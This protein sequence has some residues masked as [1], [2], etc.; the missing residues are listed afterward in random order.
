MI[1]ADLLIK[2][3]AQLLTMAGHNETPKRGGDLADPGA[4]AGGAVAALNGVITAVG[5]TRVLEETVALL[6]HARAYDAWGKVV[7]PC[8][9]EPHTHLVFGGSRQAEFV[10]RLQGKT[11]LEIMQAGGGILNSVQATAAASFEELVETAR[12]RLDLLARH[13][14]GTVE[15]KSGYGLTVEEELRMLRVVH[16]LDRTHPLDLIPTFLGAHAFPP[17]YRGR[18]DEYVALVTGEMIPRV[19]EEKLA[20]FCDVFCDIGVFTLPQAR[21]VLEAGKEF[22]LLP[23]MH[24]DEL[25]SF[26]GAELAAELGAVSADHLLKAS[27]AGIAALAKAGVIAVLLPG[28]AFYLNED[29]APAREMIRQGVAV[30]LSTDR[31]PGSSP[32]EATH[33]ILTL[34]CLKMKMLPAEALA[35]ATINAAHAVGAA[36]RVG[37]LEVGKQADILVIDAPDYDYIPYH[38][39][40]S[41][42]N[43][44]YKKGRRIA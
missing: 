10:M 27:P 32:T 17:E 6:P 41:L 25:A 5:P 7:M 15:I 12:R 39:G 29:Y 37:S 44:V 42:V 1:Q 8:F 22:G 13:G 2:N 38:Y 18:E 31:N 3:A 20:R 30:A 35:A 14:V 19:A 16:E 40:T 36:R 11:Y 34:A 33:L 24:A 26:G 9:V 23:K 43:A 4:V 28:T 21:R